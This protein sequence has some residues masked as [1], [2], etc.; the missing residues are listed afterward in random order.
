MDPNVDDVA[1]DNQVP[2]G[3][4]VGCVREEAEVEGIEAVAGC[5][6]AAIR[7]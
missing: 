7:W 2:C 1:I 5:Q 3:I 6:L 4:G